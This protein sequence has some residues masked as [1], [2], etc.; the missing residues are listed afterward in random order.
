MYR[1]ASWCWVGHAK[2]VYLK[3]SVACGSDD[4]IFLMK[5]VRENLFINLRLPILTAKCPVR[6]IQSGTMKLKV[7]ARLR[8]IY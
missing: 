8:K 2:K 3:L 5:S 7:M 4:G 6:H 1:N